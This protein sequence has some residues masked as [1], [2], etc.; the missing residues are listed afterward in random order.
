MV[1]LWC[2][3]FL[4]ASAVLIH[5]DSWYWYWSSCEGHEWCVP[6]KIFIVHLT[7]GSLYISAT[8]LCRR[9]LTD[10]FAFLSH[11]RISGCAG[12]T[13]YHYHHLHLP[14][15]EVRWALPSFPVVALVTHRWGE[16]LSDQ[17]TASC[18][19]LLLLHFI[20]SVAKLLS[21]TNNSSN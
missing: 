12:V 6:V 1:S 7:K 21:L 16:L 14:Q 11:C 17:A 10:T 18:G 13:W 20:T 3:M 8:S 9:C 5:N 15:V 19:S 2:S 4:S